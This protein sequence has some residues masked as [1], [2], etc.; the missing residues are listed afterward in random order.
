MGDPKENDD[1]GSGIVKAIYCFHVPTR[2]GSILDLHRPVKGLS[3][4]GVLFQRTLLDAATNIDLKYLIVCSN[5]ILRY[6][7]FLMN[8]GVFNI[9]LSNS[10]KFK[11]VFNQNFKIVN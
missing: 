6:L 3:F 1:D 11:N 7:I 9:D 10:L 2:A 8:L 5:G 4:M